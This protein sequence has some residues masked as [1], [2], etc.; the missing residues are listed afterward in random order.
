MGS[1][2]RGGER[3]GGVVGGHGG[4]AV[5]GRVLAVLGARGRVAPW[6]CNTITYC[7]IRPVCVVQILCKC[8]IVRFAWIFVTSIYNEVISYLSDMS[9]FFC[10]KLQPSKVS[11]FTEPIKYNNSTTTNNLNK[12]AQRA[13]ERSPETEGF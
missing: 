5:H 10:A 3:G 4:G 6:T 13:L 9:L 8:N 11:D 2:P 7:Q 12:R 1:H